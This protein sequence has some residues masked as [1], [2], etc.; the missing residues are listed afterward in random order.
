LTVAAV[1]DNTP[2]TPDEPEK[3]RK[4]SEKLKEKVAVK[5]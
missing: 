5:Q 2:T 1:A 4:D 3:A